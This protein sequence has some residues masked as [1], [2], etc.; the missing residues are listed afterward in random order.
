M[1]NDFKDALNIY[2]N[3]YQKYNVLI[4]LKTST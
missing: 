2:N 3:I 1:K 4:N